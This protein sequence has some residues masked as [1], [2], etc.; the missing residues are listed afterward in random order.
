MKHPI[1]NF[2]ISYH[3][4]IAVIIA[5][6]RYRN[7]I[8]TE[9]LSTSISVSQKA[10]TFSCKLSVCI[11]QCMRKKMLIYITFLYE[12]TC[13][14]QSVLLVFLHIMTYDRSLILLSQYTAYASHYCFAAMIPAACMRIH[15]YLF[16]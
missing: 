16:I 1:C 3:R 12:S 2:Q 10:F 9:W 4:I 13:I 6:Y 15:K 14:I 7:L 11:I 5:A 8:I